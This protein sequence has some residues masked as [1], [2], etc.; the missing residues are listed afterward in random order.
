MLQADRAERVVDR[1]EPSEDAETLMQ[2]R[3]DLGKRDIRAR[4]NQ[5]AQIGLMRPEQRPAVA[6]KA[7][8]RGVADRPHA[9]SA[10]SPPPG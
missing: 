8:R 6:A 2:L 5:P 4:F 7:R 3:L 9:A 1:R 10:S